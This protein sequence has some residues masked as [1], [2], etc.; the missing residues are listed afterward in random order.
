MKLTDIYNQYYGD[1]HEAAL[2]AVWE[3][4]VENG[5]MAV[6]NNTDIVTLKTSIIADTI[7]PVSDVPSE[8][9]GE[10]PRTV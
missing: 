8:A 5:K 3:Y 4:G 10:W 7:D 6:L 2:Q 9:P 1:S